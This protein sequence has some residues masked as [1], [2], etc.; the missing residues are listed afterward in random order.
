MS[1]AVTLYER[2]NPK[3]HIP[4]APLC[5]LDFYINRNSPSIETINYSFHSLSLISTFNICDLCS[6]LLDSGW[7]ATKQVFLKSVYITK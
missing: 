3:G 4:S 1:L 5:P 7:T 2:T 6:G